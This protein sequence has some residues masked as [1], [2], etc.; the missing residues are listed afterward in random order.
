MADVHTPEQ[1]SYNMSQI[2]GRNTRPEKKLRSL[3]HQNGLRFRI[4]DNRLPGHPDIV[5]PKYRSIIFV[6]GC[7]WHRH[8]GCRYASV[9][10]SHGDFWNEKF[11][12]NVERD[13]KN[14]TLLK[15]MG[16]YT[17]IVW[18]CEL[19][20]DASAVVKKILML[21]RDRQARAG[22]KDSGE[23]TSASLGERDSQSRTAD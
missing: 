11:S 12:Q 5:L 8:P 9:P 22:G 1:R 3:L 2:K 21:L 6:H 14:L 23:R 13:R 4:H 16:W 15:K 20:K 19:K 18:E 7:F 17:I 10:E